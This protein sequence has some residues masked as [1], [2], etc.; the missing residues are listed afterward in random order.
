MSRGCFGSQAAL[1]F[2]EKNAPI[3]GSDTIKKASGPFYWVL[4][5]QAVSTIRRSDQG[6]II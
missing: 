5:S 1:R 2:L 4:N 3:K 6:S